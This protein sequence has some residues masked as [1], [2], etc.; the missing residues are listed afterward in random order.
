M[1]IKLKNNA[2]SFITANITSS[3]TAI[4]LVSGGSFPTLSSGEYFYGTLEDTSG[5]VEIVKVTA[6][7][8][9]ILTVVRGQDGSTPRGFPA[10]SR[11]ELRVNVASVED[12]ARKP[13]VN[14]FTGDGATTSFTLSADSGNLAVANMTDAY[15]SG[16]YQSKSSYSLSG[17]QVVFS[18]APPLNAVIE[19]VV[20]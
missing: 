7:T 19:V 17:S 9:N 10:S 12:I 1:P 6:R 14:S 3:Q 18:E 5:N 13:L 16:V 4:T 2:S 8:G 15:I 20:R 11:F